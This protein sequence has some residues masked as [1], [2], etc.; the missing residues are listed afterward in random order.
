MNALS[1]LSLLLPL[2]AAPLAV[3]AAAAASA[4]LPAPADAPLQADPLLLSGRLENGFS[5][6]IRPTKEPVGQASLRLCVETGA[7][8]ET[9]ETSG[10]SH[11]VEHMVFNGSRHFRRGELI[12][13][14]QSHGLAFGS[15]ANALTGMKDTVYMLD[16]PKLSP[17]TLNFALTTLRDIAD[18]ATMLD[19]D[20]ERERG[21]LLSELRAQDSASARADREKLG[22]L[23]GGTRVM[24]FQPIGREEVIRH[25]PA[26]TI[27]AYYREHYVPSRMCLI[28]AGDVEPEKAEAW[29]REYFASMEARPAPERPAIGAPTDM[30][31]GAF[32]VPDAEAANSTV[33]MAVV[34]PWQERPDTLAQRVAD[35]P[36]Q[37]AC[38]M[39]NRRLTLLARQADQPYVSAAAVGREDAGG[40]AELF[41]FSVITQP[42]QWQEGLT[43]AVAELR[44]ALLYGF[45]PSELKEAAQ[46]FAARAHNGLEHW[47]RVSAQVIATR[48]VNAW[49]NNKA[50]TTPA[51][52]GRAC[53]VGLRALLARPELCR[54]AL[55]RACE[56]ERMRLILS[57]KVAEGATA[58]Q[59]AATCAA[60][61]SAEVSPPTE[62]RLKPF[63]YEHIGEPGK[64]VERQQ[65]PELG[66]TTLRLSNGVRVNL[67]PMGRG[68]GRIYVSAAVE[69]GS[70]RLPRVSA[71]ADLAQAVMARGGLEAHSADELSRLFTGRQVQSSFSM[72]DER[73][74]FSGTTHARDLELQCKLLCASILH[75]GFRPEGERQLRRAVPAFLREVATTPE[76]AFGVQVTRSCFGED[77]R[78]LLSTAEQFAA[79]NT[80]MVKQALSPFLEKGALELTLVGDFAVEDVLP[81]LERTFGAMPPRA[82]EFTPLP[83]EARQVNMQP[84]G[85]SEVLYYDGTVDKTLVAEVRPAGDGRDL[86]RNRRLHVLRAIAAARLFVYLRAEL[87]ESYSP[88]VQLD[89]RQGYENAATL[90][91]MS[92]GVAGNHEKVAAAMQRA[93]ASLAQ[94]EVSEEEFRLA[95]AP[96]VAELDMSYRRPV[97]WVN[98]LSRL[99]SEPQTLEWLRDG[100]RDVASI[101]PEEIRALARE[102][103]GSGKVNCY[104]I[105]PAAVAEGAAAVAE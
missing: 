58:E 102:V 94:G 56:T 27:R 68:M 52:D 86:R 5:Y 28:I 73:F 72:D 29:V 93:F 41:S 12:A 23:L 11:F 50:F 40:A 59:L 88:I 80:A 36:L 30:G 67:R 45:T 63:A 1:S 32:V 34:S 95:M 25:C 39:L 105:L 101:T 75:P 100:R 24:D 91:A 20:I 53:L 51:E 70:L 64:V 16:L 103:F 61:F 71:L 96:Y 65:V 13:A 31:A 92:I 4:A 22:K 99:Q 47:E 84:W 81:V 2:A 17:E 6:L 7:L 42:G 89:E 69:G 82:A 76:G 49:S 38:A 21:I 3:A 83:A 18:G 90:S 37:L 14:L 74:V 33:T 9:E 10:I 26:E 48:L 97:F 15:A 85:R 79:V 43:A 66:T 87:G 54:E 62:T 78:L 19:E 98:A 46:V 35:L 60:A 55:A 104:Q 44:R 57:G 77:C 8:D